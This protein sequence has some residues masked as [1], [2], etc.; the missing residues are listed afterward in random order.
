MELQEHEPELSKRVKALRLAALHHAALFFNKMVDTMEKQ[1]G[2]VLEEAKA[3]V[4][5]GSVGSVSRCFG[6]LKPVSVSVRFPVAVWSRSVNTF[7]S[8]CRAL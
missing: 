7:K 6:F 5:P 1:A 8:T 4:V 2:A 3:R